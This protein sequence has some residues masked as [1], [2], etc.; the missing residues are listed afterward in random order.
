M[1]RKND[2]TDW[3]AGFGAPMEATVPPAMRL[4]SEF[5]PTL[6]EGTLFYMPTSLPAMSVTKE[7]GR[8]H[9]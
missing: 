4:G 5:M 7:I 1:R 3:D 2:S 8:A 9:V 6:N